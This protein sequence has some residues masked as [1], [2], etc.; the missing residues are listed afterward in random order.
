[1]H[2]E[3]FE[4]VLFEMEERLKKEKECPNVTYTIILFS[5]AEEIRLVGVRVEKEN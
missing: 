3:L 2:A 5:R 1:M 4:I